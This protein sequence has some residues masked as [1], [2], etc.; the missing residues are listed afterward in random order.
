[1]QSGLKNTP[2]TEDEQNFIIENYLLFPVKRV[3]KMVGRSEYG[4]F[5]FLRRKGLVV[6]PELVEQ[7]KKDSYIKKGATPINKGKKLTEY[8]SPEAIERMKAT[9]F[10]KGNLPANTAGAD[11][12]IRIRFDH[13]RQGGKAY[14]YIRLSLSKW[15]LYH[16][17]LWEQVNGAIPPKH[18]LRFK[19]GDS[20]NCELDN[21]ELITFEQNMEL[22]TIHRFPP[23]LKEII[24]LNHKLKRKINEKL[25][26]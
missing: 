11:G 18:V 23:E 1:M 17:Y 8:C 21:L 7:R 4:V 3:A 10:K 22:N 2:F 16:R 14:K 15:V 26:S 13:P 12:E 6:P 19:D 24:K 25:N 20:L 9:Q 5:N